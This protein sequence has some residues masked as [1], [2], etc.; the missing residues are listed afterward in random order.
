MTF[1][2][3]TQIFIVRMLLLQE[4]QGVLAV[5]P[6]DIRLIDLL[7]GHTGIIQRS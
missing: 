1:F 5:P 2:L 3:T 4:L 6:I 7:E